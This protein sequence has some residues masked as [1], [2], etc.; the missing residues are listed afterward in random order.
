MSDQELDVAYVARLA[1]LQ[2]SDE[3]AR[4]FQGQLA[5]VLKHVD[6]LR[7]VDVSQ[8]ETAA[9]AVPVFDVWREDE[10]RPSLPRE[11]ALQ[12]AP[13]PAK[14]LFIVTKVVE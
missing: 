4:L 9:H 7:E 13:R 8:V 6:K 14:G 1:R 2:L 12:N 3:E 5:Q 10:T 11:A